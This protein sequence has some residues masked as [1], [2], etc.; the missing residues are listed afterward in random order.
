M[1]YGVRDQANVAA[2]FIMLLSGVEL[3]RCRISRLVILS[4]HFTQRIVRRQVETV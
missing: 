1:A 3:Q 4:C 2:C